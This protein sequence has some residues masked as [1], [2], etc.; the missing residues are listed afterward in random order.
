MIEASFKME[1]FDYPMKGINRFV[2][3]SSIKESD[4]LHSQVPGTVPWGLRQLR[5]C[6]ELE[7]DRRA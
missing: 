1:V 7:L 3:L 2:S 6:E 4:L 5:G